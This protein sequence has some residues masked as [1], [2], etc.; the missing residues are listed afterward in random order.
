MKILTKIFWF[1]LL[2]PEYAEKIAKLEFKIEIQNKS[3][4]ELGR[5]LSGQP[6][7]AK[8][9]WLELDTASIQAA[10]AA[11]VARAIEKLKDKPARKENGGWFTTK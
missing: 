4:V 3:I 7:A 6:A 1:E 2:F 5:R 10:P 8:S 9:A 11:S